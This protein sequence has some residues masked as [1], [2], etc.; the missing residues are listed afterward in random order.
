VAAQMIEHLAA[1]YTGTFVLVKGS[2]D[3]P[4]A[5]IIEQTA[6][7]LPNHF[8]R[9]WN[10]IRPWLYHAYEDILSSKRFGL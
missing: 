4:Y 1:L 6:D 2:G 5:K 7:C 3:T 10:D 9:Y 8:E